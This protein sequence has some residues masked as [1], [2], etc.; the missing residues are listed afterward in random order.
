MILPLYTFGTTIEQFAAMRS[1]DLVRY[2]TILKDSQTGKIVAHIQETGLWRSALDNVVHAPSN[3]VLSVINTIQNEQIKSRLTG[4]ETMVGG[5]Q[6]LQLVNLAASVVGIYQ[7]ITLNSGFSPF[8]FVL[9]IPAWPG[10]R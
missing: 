10:W 2:G 6:N 9:S 5:L 4:L 1:G 8:R 3:P 7:S